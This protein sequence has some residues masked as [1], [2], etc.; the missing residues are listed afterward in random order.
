MNS[1]QSRQR[2]QASRAGLNHMRRNVHART[3]NSHTFPCYTSTQDT[4]PTSTSWSA[5]NTFH[6][7][8]HITQFYVYSSCAPRFWGSILTRSPMIDFRD[9]HSHSNI[10]LYPS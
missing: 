5:I 1:F 6:T 10:L 2:Y 9:G 3:S 4:F 8:I 7:T